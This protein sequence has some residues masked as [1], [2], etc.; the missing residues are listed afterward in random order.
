MIV[1]HIFFSGWK[2]QNAKGTILRRF[3]TKMEE[4]KSLVGNIMEDA[5]NKDIWT[6]C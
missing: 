6:I 1:L 4:K 3:Q 2:Q 5:A